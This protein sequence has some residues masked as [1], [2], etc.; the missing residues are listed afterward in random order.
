MKST[1]G[2][3]WSPEELV[4]LERLLKEYPDE[5]VQGHRWEK[6]ARAL[7][8]R[9]PRQVAS[10]VLKIFAK[11]ARAGVPVPG[12]F[13]TEVCNPIL[14]EIFSWKCL[15]GVQCLLLLCCLIPAF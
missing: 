12:K 14:P 13:N 11:M 2:K 1:K 4:K 15:Q 6:I 7:G 9:T 10:R 8:N 3:T 5:P